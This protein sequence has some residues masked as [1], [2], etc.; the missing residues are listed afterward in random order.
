MYF[1]L[2]QESFNN[3]LIW[4]TKLHDWTQKIKD[5]E[6][7]SQTST[8]LRT[9]KNTNIIMTRIES[10]KT[11]KLNNRNSH[12]MLFNR[13]KKDKTCLLKWVTI[14]SNFYLCATRHT[15]IIKLKSV[16]V[17]MNM[18]ISGANSR[19]WVCFF[20]HLI[21]QFWKKAYYY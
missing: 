15:N 13:L 9:N 8:S 21:A 1:I 16:L 12:K 17:S 18:L 4:L 2:K 3:L 7:L 20:F 5:W 11:K 19:I 6:K 10:L 14:D